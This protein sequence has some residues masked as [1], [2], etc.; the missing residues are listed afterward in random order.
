MV[1]EQQAEE[2]IEHQWLAAI[3]ITN[4]QEIW[5]MIDARGIEELPMRQSA[6][7]YAH[8]ANHMEQRE[9]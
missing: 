1:M 4:S 9:V 5:A 8:A 7:M 2:E 3:M 6:D